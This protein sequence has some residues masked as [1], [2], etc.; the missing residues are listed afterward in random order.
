MYLKQGIGPTRC[1][2]HGISHRGTARWKWPSPLLRMCLDLR[3][4]DRCHGRSAILHG[5]HDKTMCFFWVFLR[6][7]IWGMS[8]WFVEKVGLVAIGCEGP[9]VLSVKTCGGWSLGWI[10]CNL[11]ASCV[12]QCRVCR[13]KYGK[14]NWFFKNKNKLDFLD[15][16]KP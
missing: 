1:V 14:S 13:K 7:N 12:H 4:W 15:L 5:E 3:Q 11:P 9:R 2:E 10:Y 16:T 6:L 8:H